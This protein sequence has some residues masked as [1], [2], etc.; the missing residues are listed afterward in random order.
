MHPLAITLS[1]RVAAYAFMISTFIYKSSA[2][3]TYGGLHH[4]NATTENPADPRMKWEDRKGRLASSQARTLTGSPSQALR[5]YQVR[6]GRYS[7][8]MKRRLS[9]A[10]ALLGD[11]KRHVW[12]IIEAAKKGR[13]I[14]LTTHSMEEVDVLSD[15]L[16]IMAK[17]RLRWIGYLNQHFNVLIKVEN[18]SFLTHVIPRE[19]YLTVST[20]V[21]SNYVSV[22][23]YFLTIFLQRK[24]FRE[25]QPREKEFGIE[26]AFT[27][28]RMMTFK[29]PNGLVVEIP[30]GARYIRIPGTESPH[31]PQDLVVEVYWQ[32]DPLIGKLC[33]AGHSAK[34]AV[35]PN[36]QCLPSLTS[37]APPN[38][39]GKGGIVKRNRGQLLEKE[40]L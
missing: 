8:G 28:G 22:A 40:K 6:A 32:Q 12:D 14:V 30:V 38:T 34:I 10:A 26:T 25:L 17:G 23:F 37:T 15:R 7:G 39:L 11:P 9:V 3:M 27:E 13:S 5:K 18:N 33:M 36:F 35:P 2:A 20:S 19:N 21:I 4:L 1:F 16:G 31:Y 24:F 29:M